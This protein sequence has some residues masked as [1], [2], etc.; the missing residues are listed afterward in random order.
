MSL[1]LT[2]GL[3]VKFCWAAADPGPAV[4][5]ACIFS[6]P[7]GSYCETT[8]ELCIEREVVDGWWCVSATVFNTLSAL[9]PPPASEM[10]VFGANVA[11]LNGDCAVGVPDFIELMENFGETGG[12][13]P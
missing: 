7:E 1:A 10:H 4:Y 12:V 3:L 6:E 8:E 2:L 9:D 11:D 5:H 13:L